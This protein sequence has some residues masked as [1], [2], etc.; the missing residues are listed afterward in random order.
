MLLAE[1]QGSGSRAFLP[2]QA[3]L[4]G[5]LNITRESLGRI[6]REL[7]LEGALLRI[8]RSWVEVL[9]CRVDSP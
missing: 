8:D 5:L 9:N 3:D 4:A 2:R 7:E 6:L 1:I